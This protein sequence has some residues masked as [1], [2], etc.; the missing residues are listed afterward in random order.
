MKTLLETR[1]AIGFTQVEAANALHI[2][3]RKYQMYESSKGK[4]SLEMEKIYDEILN[5]LKKYYEVTPTTGFLTIDKIKQVV[6]KESKKHKEIHAVYLFGSY[7]RGEQTEESDVDLLIVD[8]VMG[9]ALGGY[10]MDIRESL[11]KDVDIVSHRQ[12]K[13]PDFIETVLT[14]AVRLY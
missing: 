5:E 11:N 12:L 4:L 10:Y 14:D 8:D 1:Q 6:V 3:R 13:D 9:F 7:A 2:S